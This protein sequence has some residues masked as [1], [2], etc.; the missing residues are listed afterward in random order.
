METLSMALGSVGIRQYAA[1]KRQKSRKKSRLPRSG[2]KCSRKPSISF[3]PSETTTS[4]LIT[5]LPQMP[6]NLMDTS[7]PWAN[8]SQHGNLHGR[9]KSITQK[10]ATGFAQAFTQAGITR[11]TAAQAW[12]QDIRTN[13]RSQPCETERDHVGV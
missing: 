6:E 1:A 13:C 11:S 5:T 8:T 3:G 9:L 7:S 10:S 4:E 12:L 2:L